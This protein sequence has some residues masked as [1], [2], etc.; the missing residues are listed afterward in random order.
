[1]FYKIVEEY[2]AIIDD[3]TVYEFR[4]F[5]GAS[6]LLAKIEFIDTSVLYIKDYLF[7]DGK[8][9]YSCG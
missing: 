9:K 5:G 7:I 2:S 8:R 1:M 4:R 3:F 6:S